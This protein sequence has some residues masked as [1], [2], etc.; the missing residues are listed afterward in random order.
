MVQAELMELMTTYCEETAFS[1]YVISYLG[2]VSLRWDCTGVVDVV[3][4]TRNG[5]GQS[6]TRLAGQ[7]PVAVT[8]EITVQEVEVQDA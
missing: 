2:S 3:D 5:Q 8:P 7:F 4:Y 1:S 6:L